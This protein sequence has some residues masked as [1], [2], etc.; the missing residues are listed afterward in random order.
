M[1]SDCQV[2]IGLSRKNFTSQPI[3]LV[4][5]SRFNL[6]LLWEVVYCAFE[7]AGE[8]FNWFVILYSNFVYA[9]TPSAT[10]LLNEIS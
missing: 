5:V 2:I 1:Q 4:K 8:L 3:L 6:S 10:L 9:H 7:F